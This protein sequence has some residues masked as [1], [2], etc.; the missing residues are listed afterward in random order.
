[1]ALP[2][3]PVKARLP[4]IDKPNVVWRISERAPMGEWVNKG[5]RSPQ[6]SSSDPSRDVHDSWATSSFDLLGGS[7]VIESTGTEPADF[8][9]Q[10]FAPLLK[11]PDK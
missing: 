7:E 8:F 9:D 6:P 2:K 1:M 5:V 11:G 4:S 3:A 10:L